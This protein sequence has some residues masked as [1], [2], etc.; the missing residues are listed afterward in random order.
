MTG[1]PPDG[2]REILLEDLIED[3]AAHG[4]GGANGADRA[5]EVAEAGSAATAPGIDADE[6]QDRRR[7]LRPQLRRILGSVTEY[8]HLTSC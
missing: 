4:A 7:I 1:V 8:R 3:E 5:S 2:N 6:L